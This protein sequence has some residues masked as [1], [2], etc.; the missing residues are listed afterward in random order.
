MFKC[1]CQ[2]SACLLLLLFS[3]T[4]FAEN[5]TF[6]TS[7]FSGSGNCSRCHDDITDTSGDD[8]SIVR[9]WGASM[10][11]N[12]TKDPFWRAKVA[13]ELERNP[14]L[15]TVINDT[16][17]KCHAPMA[18]YEVT[19]VQDGE[20]Y[21][22]GPEGVL[23]PEHA[24]YDAGMNGVSCTACHQITDD[25]LGTLD[26][27]SGQYN[28]NHNKTVYGQYSDIFGRP[29]INNTS[30]TPAY[31]AHVSGSALCATCHNLKTPYVNPDGEVVA[32]SP[33]S[34]FPEQMPYTEWQNSIFDDEGSNP[35]SCQDC[36]MPKTT[37]KISNRPGWLGA[38]DGFGRHHLVGA[39]TVMLTMLRDNA[40]QLD[41]TSH[42]LDS[43]I[44]RARDMLRSAASIE[45]VSAIVSN[46]IL[47][48][49][50][51]V[52][53]TS[54]HKVP[55]SYPSRRMW[56]H[57][58]VT[59]SDN[60]VVFESGRFNADGSIE[61]ADN[62]VNRAVFE[63]HYPLISSADQVQIYEAVMGDTDG[64]ITYTLLHGA[65]YL[66]DN[67][68]T[69]KGFSKFNVPDD[70]AV[71]G[72]A[73]DDTDFDLGS[74]VVTYRIPVAVTGDLGVT[75]SLN[76]QTIAHGFLQDLYQ[77]EHLEQVQ[78]FKSLYEAQHLKHEQIASV[79]T[80]AVSGDH[81]DGSGDGEGKE[82]LNIEDC[83]KDVDYEMYNIQLKPDGKWQMESP[84]G[85]YSGKYEVVIP[86]ESLSLSFNKNSKSRFYGYIGQAGKSLCG[87]KR[88][89]LSTKVKKFIV[90][91]DGENNAWKLVLIV[92]YKATD[93]T[94]TKKGAYKVTVENTAYSST[95]N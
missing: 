67:R 80:T 75:A 19:R 70:V 16:C 37:S 86:G 2:A 14:H 85:S 83:G 46:G 45:I 18:Y 39:N 90:K 32:A 59:D 84:S 48:V 52:V 92:K 89:L 21:L 50:V 36:H 25:A 73:F 64:D 10:M 62:D 38:R 72:H 87:V 7:L 20:I 56:I 35:R 47:E 95:S 5:T 54:G 41:I 8:V 30:Y 76:Y 65:Q 9:D 77:E 55:T 26:G 44:S 63:Q 78:T 49:H 12:S 79:Q 24:L 82:V 4:A 60:N 6:T 29:M 69:P 91:L 27:F 13:T 43:G 40:A 57:F 74:D 66:K 61:G 17:T 31:S 15:S 11:A 94:A 68:L 28:I 1:L 42:D 23:N 93:G 53:N 88:K 81:L 33:E 71:H 22:F 3:L 51:R 34:K 58:R